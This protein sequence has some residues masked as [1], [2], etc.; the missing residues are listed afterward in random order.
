MP[1]DYCV[2]T[3]S[4]VDSDNEI[5]RMQISAETDVYTSSTP[6]GMVPKCVIS[7]LSHGIQYIDDV[8]DVDGISPIQV[9]TGPDSI[10]S[11]V[12]LLENTVY[13]M[14]VSGAF[15]SSFDYLKENSGEIS[16]R[17]LRYTGADGEGVYILQFRGYV[18][19][20]CFDVTFGEKRFEIPFEV[21]SRKIGYLT[22]YPSMLS[23]IAEFST[24]LLMSVRSPLHTCYDLS[25]HGRETVYEDFLVLD[26]I[27][28]KLDFEGMYRYVKD[29][30]HSELVNH[31][32]SVPAGIASD[33]DPADLAFLVY[34]DNL[35]P[36]DAGPIAGMYAPAEVSERSWEDS[37]DTP[38]NRVVKD[39]VLTMGAM[40][41]SLLAIGN[42]A[43]SDYVTSRLFEMSECLDAIASDQW[44][45]DIG[46]LRMIPYNSTVLQSKFGY[47]E[48]FH[49]YQILG[50]GAAFRQD[51]AEDLLSG[52]N[53]KVHAVYEYWCYTRLYSCLSE[54]SD[55][56]PVLPTRM[57]C[58]KWAMTIG[59]KTT[60]HIP[61]ANSRLEVDLYYNANF[62]ES[63]LDFRSYSVRLRPDFTL[64]VRSSSARNR[65]FIVNFDAKYKAKPLVEDDVDVEA[66][67]VGMDSWEYDI[68]KMHTYRDALIHSCGSYVLFPGNNY[69]IFKKPWDQRRWDLRDRSFIP[70]VGAIPLVPGDGRDNQ[71]HETII[72][73]FEKIAEI[74]EGSIDVEDLR[75]YLFRGQSFTF[76][77]KNE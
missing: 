44:L 30:R 31:T 72:Q 43:T 68:C 17:R 63:S 46:D 9:Y 74:S 20:G 50:L 53:K 22:D 24:A 14:E 54:M 27:F 4:F 23:D 39:L 64:K 29:N 13:E 36:M 37:F 52:Q 18:G 35:V 25:D 58:G 6:M 38:E 3:L 21:R 42:A 2:L 55:D 49:M 73:I 16:L 33:I 66:D 8:K 32:D 67:E 76:S 19:K 51:D 77:V 60:F 28:S 41:R 40:V 10:P 12:L 48:L 75:D 7:E 57:S 61:M 34:G 70:S 65:T 47:S 15:D 11:P 71:L 1:S 59:R 26:F 45:M 69:S 5:G 62:S 56:V